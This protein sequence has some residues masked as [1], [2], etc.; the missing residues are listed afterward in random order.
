MGH[1]A[2]LL[3]A[4]RQSP[5]GVGPP[6]GI[7]RV[8]KDV[9]VVRLPR[10]WRAAASAHELV[11][12]RVHVQ[13]ASGPLRRPVDRFAEVVREL[14]ELHRRRRL[15]ATC[16]PAARTRARNV[17][18]RAVAKSR[19]ATRRGAHGVVTHWRISAAQQG[20]QAYTVHA[21]VGSQLDAQHV[22]EGRQHIGLVDEV[23]AAA[24]WRHPAGPTHDERHAV[25]ALPGWAAGVVAVLLELGEAD[26]GRAAIVAA[27]QHECLVRYAAL[28][29]SL[30]HVADGRI[31][32]HQQI[33]VG[34]DPRPT[35]PFSVDSQRRVWGGERQIEKEPTC[36][37]GLLSDPAHRAI[38][39]RGQRW[40]QPPTLTSRTCVSQ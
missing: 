6:L 1:R 22:R 10:S 28:L 16:A 29:Q 7:S 33:C 32:L 38:R 21:L 40:L 13:D 36:R 9:D 30:Q 3:L 11:E 19:Q 39:N 8:A 18:P 37:T 26:E 20:Q 34:I 5:R 23:V 25:P 24:L 12:E 31:R 2:C 17:F 14:V 27:E 4:S 15:S 35:S